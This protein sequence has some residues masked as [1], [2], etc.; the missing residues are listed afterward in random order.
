MVLFESALQDSKLIVE[1]KPVGSSLAIFDLA[2]LMV[3]T[4]LVLHLL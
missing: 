3:Y 2:D 4:S 1:H